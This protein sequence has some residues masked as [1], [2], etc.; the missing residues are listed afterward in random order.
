MQ[1][2]IKDLLA[3]LVIFVVGSFLLF[4][5]IILIPNHWDEGYPLSKLWRY[6]DF[7]KKFDFDQAKWY[8]VRDDHLPLIHYLLGFELNHLGFLELASNLDQPL[9]SVDLNQTLVEN[10]QK[11]NFAL[12][13][14]IGRATS[15][16]FGIA[17]LIIIFVM[18]RLFF[19]RVVSFFSIMLLLFN[20][21][22][23]MI[24]P[25]IFLEPALLFLIL[26]GMLLVLFWLK[27]E[28]TSRILLGMAIGLIAGLSYLTKI[29]GLVSILMFIGT[30]LV[31]LW[32]TQ[33]RKKIIA[34]SIL[35][36]L[37]SFIFVTIIFFPPFW[38]EPLAL[39]R[40]LFK[41]RLEITQDYQNDTDYYHIFD[42]RKYRELEFKA[43]EFGGEVRGIGEAVVMMGYRNYW[44]YDPALRRIGLPVQLFLLIITLCE[45]LRKA[46]GL[47][48]KLS[49]KQ[50]IHWDKKQ[51][52]FSMSVITMFLVFGFV[53]IYS[54]KLDFA[55]Y[56]YLFLVISTFSAASGGNI[57]LHSISQK[58]LKHISHWFKQLIFPA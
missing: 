38:H 5:Q 16:F 15:A 13:F 25:R 41:W 19:N 50:K 36:G 4:K 17:S 8:P 20:P 37:F 26:L 33:T 24:S 1:V 35:L 2:H 34:S 58:K 53:Q 18:L 12:P 21:L 31:N 57:I 52:K 56:Y 6:E 54:L 42:R 46:L 45:L 48:I 3:V 55:R 14:F 9:F 22:Y 47:I 39:S 49:N 7:F 30:G 11:V 32:F 29:N 51:L 27:S 10:Y 40:D 28:G 44:Y 43:A 23:L